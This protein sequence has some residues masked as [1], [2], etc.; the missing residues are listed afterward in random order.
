MSA[1]PVITKIVLGP[2]LNGALMTPEEF[3]AV[4][5][6]DENYRYELIHGVLIVNPP[7]LPAETG[8]N[9]ELGYVLRYYKEFHPKGSALDL[10]IPEHYI[11][12][13]DSRRRADR[14]I[15]AGLSR[16]PDW[17]RE[18][19]T[20][21]AEFVSSGRRDWQRDYVEKRRE[22]MELK[23][24]E[25]WIID[26][27]RRIMTVVRNHPKGPKVITVQERETYS[28]PL[29]PGFE[30]PLARLLQVAD[31]LDQPKERTRKTNARRSR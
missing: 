30:L 22:Y 2:E 1:A 16:I 23:I 9:E 29:L 8:P 20:I 31:I 13:K 5:E 14:A 3:D 17:R 4:E 10:T 15:W 26:R 25:Y 7:P 24:A 27:F 28:T 18:L 19:P 6:C 21:V 11:R 12:T